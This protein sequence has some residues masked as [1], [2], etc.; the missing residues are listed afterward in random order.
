MGSGSCQ[1]IRSCHYRIVG[2]IIPSILE[3]YVSALYL[4]A[5]YFLLL[6]AQMGAYGKAGMEMEMETE[7]EMEK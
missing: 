5:K 7:M 2:K 3:G 4:T 6:E 1:L